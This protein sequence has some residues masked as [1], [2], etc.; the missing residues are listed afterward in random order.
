MPATPATE[1]ETSQSGASDPQAAAAGVTAGTEP[2]GHS[3]ALPLGM[4]QVA[5]QAVVLKRVNPEYPAIARRKRIEGLVRLEVKLSMSGQIVE[6]IRILESIPA[7]D[8]AALSALR[9][10]QF[11]PARNNRGQAIGVIL[12]VPLRFVLR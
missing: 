4:H 5:Q 10:W 6:P 7:L 9:S 3:D 8:A 11:A 12:E 1:E 2:S